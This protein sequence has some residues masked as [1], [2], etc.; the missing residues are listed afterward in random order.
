VSVGFPDSGLSFTGMAY[1]LQPDGATFSPPI[2]LSFIVPQADWEGEYVVQ[3]YDYATSTWQ[4]L[5]SS[6]DPQTGVITVPVSRFCYFA[7]FAKPKVMEEVVSPTPTILIATKS[8]VETNLQIYSWFI[9]MLEKNPFM[10]VII[11]AALGV[12]VY[13]R[14]W[15]RRL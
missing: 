5:P 4:V 1:D 6:Y 2:S 9:S 10:M 3:E 11:L 13:F 14:W 7:L 8:S 15:K 12:V